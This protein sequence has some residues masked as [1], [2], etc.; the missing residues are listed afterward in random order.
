MQLSN[1]TSKNSTTPPTSQ[2]MNGPLS[3][4]SHEY[5]KKNQ[6]VSNKSQAFEDLTTSSENIKMPNFSFWMLLDFF[7]TKPRAL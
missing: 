5:L 3:A 7:F 1:D 2:K 6:R 4:T